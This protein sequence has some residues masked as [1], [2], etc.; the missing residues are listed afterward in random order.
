MCLAKTFRCHG[1]N[2]AKFT[3]PTYGPDTE[4]HVQCGTKRLKINLVADEEA[5][6]DLLQELPV[7]HQVSLDLRHR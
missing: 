3:A 1:Y 7:N 6:K 2:I 5:L 4:L